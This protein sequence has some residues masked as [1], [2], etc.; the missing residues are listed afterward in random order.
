MIEIREVLRLWL[1][2][3]GKKP[4]A[5]QLG[6]DPK[7]VRRYTRAAEACGMRREDGPDALTD[8]RL[9]ATV[10]A[11]EASPERDRGPSWSRCLEAQSQ[12]EGWLRDGLR[13]TKV[14]KLLIR[15][16]VTVPYPTL[17]RFAVAKLGFGQHAATIAVLDGEPGDELQLDT[18]W[19]GWLAPDL[20]GRRRRFRAWIFTAVRSRHRFV[21]PCF[22]ETTAS[23]IEACEEAWSFFG[24]VFRT[25]LPDNTKA[26]IHTPDPLQPHLVEAFL[27]YAQARGFQ[28][29]PARVRHAKDK[30]RVERAVP[31]VRDD[32]FAGERLISLD[33]ARRHARSWCVEQ[34]GL[35]RHSTTQRLPLEV[36]EAEEKPALR[37]APTVPYDVPLWATPKIARDH[38]AQVDRALYSLPSRF[39]GRTLRARADRTTV[40]FYDGARLVKTHPRVPRGQRSTDPEDFP[41]HKR[42]YA[43]R[44]LA[45]LR[46]QASGFGESVGR[47]ASALLDG[48]LPWTRMRRVYALL[49][50]ARKYGAA[51][52]D[53]VCSV[54]LDA[55][56][57]DVY[58]LRRMLE[59]SIPHGA[60]ADPAA[61]APAARF[62]RPTHQYALNFVPTEVSHETRHDLP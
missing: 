50:L 28:V 41:E 4:I 39:I 11:L 2:G 19:V 16:G 14:R 56:M 30:G 25:L 7:T 48:P 21:Y 32:C 35:R 33:H 60:T 22:H 29:D 55:D 6:L 9:V 23:A 52:L 59:L 13:L 17:H 24:G 8:D 40:R 47:F 45:F 38:Y 49:G 3:R 46:R 62:L 57:L 20:A 15:E 61:A 1:A 37:P 44:D 10:A 53:Q 27:E 26:I 51:R 12:I 42:A 34:Y 54:A 5:R 36:F 43:H 58:R 18:G 31:H